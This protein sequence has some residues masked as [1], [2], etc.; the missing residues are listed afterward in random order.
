VPMLARTLR[1]AELR[2][3]SRRKESMSAFVTEHQP[4]LE[5]PMRAELDGRLMVE[6]VDLVITLTESSAPL[7]FPET[8]KPGAVVCS[9]GSYNEVDFRVLLESQ[10]FIVDESEYASTMGDGG[11]WIAQGYLSRDEFMARIDA[12]ACEVVAGQKPGRVSESD[13]IVA[14][15]QGMAIGDIAFAAH[16]LNEAE[17]L[18]RGMVIDLP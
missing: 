11:A 6:G 16:A 14:L 17:R 3:Q 7:V 18:G 5:F 8:L 4:K 2:I 10:R 1:V 12:L 13:R 15:I 9:M